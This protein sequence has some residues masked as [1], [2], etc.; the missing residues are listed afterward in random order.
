MKVLF[1]IA[2]FIVLLYYVIV[3]VRFRK[4]GELP[5]PPEEDTEIMGQSKFDIRQFTT[6]T[7]KT[8]VSEKDEDL[9]TKFVSQDEQIPLDD[10]LIESEYGEEMDER[11]MA[12]GVTF[13][14]LEKVVSIVTFPNESKDD[15]HDAGRIIEKMKGS[16]LL[17]SFMD[18]V[19]DS[20]ETINRIMDEYIG[21]YE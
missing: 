9:E 10:D 2:L 3:Y 15:R 7:D 20:R 5:L 14:E 1:T 13:E 11:E 18:Q 4:R 21:N 12:E 6:E 17:N 16:E 8:L 19:Q